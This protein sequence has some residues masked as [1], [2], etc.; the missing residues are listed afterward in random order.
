M[1]FSIKLIFLP[2][3]SAPQALVTSVTNC[4]RLKVAN[5]YYNGSM[6]NA[7]EENDRPYWTDQSDTYVIWFDG[8]TGS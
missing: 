5:E 8:D 4:D 7:G 6:G 3:E 1:R 2:G